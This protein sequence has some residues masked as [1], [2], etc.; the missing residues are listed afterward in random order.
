MALE[1]M[2][3][4]MARLRA[5]PGAG[6]AA[7]RPPRA[8]DSCFASDGS[9]MHSGAGVWAGIL[10]GAPAGACTQAFPIHSSSRI[11]AGAPIEGGIFKC[12]LKSVDTALAD[13]TYGAWTPNAQQVQALKA[14]FPEG[15]CDW[16]K[17]DQGRPQGW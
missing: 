3:E 16:S 14:I 12:A 15:V 4:W 5:N 8:A 9:L 2:D 1:V 6:I 13:G 17:P 11:L 10:D 7:N